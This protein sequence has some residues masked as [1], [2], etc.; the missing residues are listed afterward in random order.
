MR[1][2]TRF[3]E[4]RVFVEPLLPVIEGKAPAAAHDASTTGPARYLT[5]CRAPA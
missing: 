4:H 3:Y 2:S 1:K 5:G